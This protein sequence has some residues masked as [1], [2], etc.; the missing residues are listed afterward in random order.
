VNSLID[1][2]TLNWRIA[3]SD[4][5]NGWEETGATTPTNKGEIQKLIT[6]SERKISMEPQKNDPKQGKKDG[7]E[8]VDKGE[9]GGK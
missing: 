8:S 4:W 9:Q 7:H 1:H 2:C 3:F 6:N 5:G